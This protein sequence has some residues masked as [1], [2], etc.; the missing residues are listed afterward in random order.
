MATVQPQDER[1][2]FSRI[3]FHR[4]A[5]LTIG[6]AATMVGVL[7]VSLKGALLE[8]PPGFSAAPDARCSLVVRLDAGE[9]ALLPEPAT[10]LCRRTLAHTTRP[11]DRGR[12]GRAAPPG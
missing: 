3:T 12:A 11:A 6:T 2:R 8:V 9:R 4:P 1:R 5:I 10:G 7:D